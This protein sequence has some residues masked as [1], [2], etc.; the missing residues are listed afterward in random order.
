MPERVPPAL[1]PELVCTAQEQARVPERW[2]VRVRTQPVP[3][4]VRVGLPRARQ[5]QP[6]PRLRWRLLWAQQVSV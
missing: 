5:V 3:G 4:R 1:V 2:T 6:V